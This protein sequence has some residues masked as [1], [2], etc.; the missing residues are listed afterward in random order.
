MNVLDSKFVVKKWPVTDLIPYEKNAKLHP[1]EQI[2]RLAA[3]IKRFGWDQPIVVDKEGVIIKGHG[4]RLAAMH[5][6]LTEVPVLVRSDLS[7]SEADA[8]RISDNAVF[9]TQ[10]DTRTLQE[11]LMRLMSDT[12]LDFSVDD[13][14]LSTK[15]H[16]LLMKQIDVAAENV[17]MTDT[18]SEIEKQR[19]EDEERVEK[20][21]REEITLS[22]AFGFKRFTREEARLVQSLISVAEE[23]SGLEGKDAFIAWMRSNPTLGVSK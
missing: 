9:G 13:L 11:E 20:A 14:G 7:K 21:D 6:G 5:L 17:I 2:E 12:E 4:R 22:E 3:T 10:F 16:D 23:F 1:P 15:D 19:T 18:N 8:V